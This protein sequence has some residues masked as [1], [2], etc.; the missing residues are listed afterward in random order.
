MSA[1]RITFYFNIADGIAYAVQLVAAL[2][3]EHCAVAVSCADQP[4]ADRIDREL[5]FRQ[6]DFIPHVRCG[7]PIADKTPIII[8]VFPERTIRPCCIN[9]SQHI[10]SPCPYEQVIEIVTQCQENRRAA[11]VRYRQWQAAGYLIEAMDRC[12]ENR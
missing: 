5:W 4:L 6:Q 1:P 2:Y 12:E 3:Q 7:S 10:F 11:R 8:D 9:L